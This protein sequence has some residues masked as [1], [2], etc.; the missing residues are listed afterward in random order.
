MAYYF[1][2]GSK[3]YF[4]TTLAAAKTVT[5]ATNANPTV[6]TSTAHGFV[7]NDE[8]LFTSGWEDATDSVYKAD[9]LTVDTLSL[10]GLNTTNTNFFAA[11]AGTGTLQK[12]SSWLEI[13]QVLSINTSGGDARFT[14][15][16]PLA[17]RNSLNVPTGFNPMS[18]TLTL[19]HD[20][21][22]AN[23]ITM[24]DVSRTLS[25]AAFKVVLGG[26]ALAYGYGYMSVSEQPSLTRNQVNQVN[27]A[28]TFLGRFITYAS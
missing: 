23:Y 11:G 15:V 20:P 6:L 27:A 19:A 25:K 26:G 17:K 7:D 12:V 8:L 13:P 1:P 2:E 24:L 5:L 28:I 18:M 10:L 14:T 3:F 21:A 4:S 22:Q 9:Q 16:E